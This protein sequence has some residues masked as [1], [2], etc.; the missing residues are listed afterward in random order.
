M[1]FRIQS[2]ADLEFSESAW[3]YLNEEQSPQAAERFADEVEEVYREIQNAP[4]RFPIRK[5]GLRASPLKKFPFSIMYFIESD[6][7]VIASVYH[8][9]RSRSSLS[10]RR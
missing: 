9:K 4:Y 1:T 5:K 7:I 2:E 10:R 8:H 3:W 6:E